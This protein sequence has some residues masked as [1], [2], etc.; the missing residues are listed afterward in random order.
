MNGIRNEVLRGGK[1][2]WSARRDGQQPRRERR[3]DGLF[4]HRGRGQDG[5]DR[6]SDE[7]KHG[8]RGYAKPAGEAMILI[9]HRTAMMMVV[10]VGAGLIRRM[11]E[12]PPTG[13]FYGAD[14]ERA[15]VA[16]E[17]LVEY[18]RHD[19]REIEHQEQGCP[20]AHARRPGLKNSTTHATRSASDPTPAPH[21]RKSGRPS[22]GSTGDEATRYHDRGAAANEGIDDGFISHRTDRCPP[23]HPAVT[24]ARSTP[25]GRKLPP[26]EVTGGGIGDPGDMGERIDTGFGTSPRGQASPMRLAT[27]SILR[28]PSTQIHSDDLQHRGCASKP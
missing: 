28:G 16:L 1:W 2:R 24:A 27:R 21:A 20:A 10:R 23:Q 18:W 19:Q 3:R 5:T 7:G 13:F 4:S 9:V 25:C 11:G 26:T 12:D 22:R 6:S 17:K 14:L 8:D 15:S